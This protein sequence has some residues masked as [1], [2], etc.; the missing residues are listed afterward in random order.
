MKIINKI[1]FWL[2]IFLGLM[3]IAIVIF[4]LVMFIGLIAQHHVTSWGEFHSTFEIIMSNLF[5]LVIGL[6]MAVMM[7]RRKIELLPEILAFVIARKLL[8]STTG[9]YDIAIGVLAIA[10][11]FSVRKYLIKC[12]GCL[13]FE[14][15]VAGGEVKTERGEEKRKSN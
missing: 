6:E 2:E 14:R 15:L 12:D 13:S 4:G 11:L 7:I 10:G 1:L 3:I 9:I 5:L 8:L